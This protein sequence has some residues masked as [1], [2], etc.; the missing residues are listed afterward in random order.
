MV[1]RLELFYLFR[2]S[3][4]VYQTPAH[5]GLP[6]EQ[7]FI[8]TPDGFRLSARRLLP[9]EPVASIVYFHGNTGNLGILN[10]IFLLLC[11]HDLQLL[12]VDYRGYGWSTETPSEEGNLYGCF[13]HC[14]L[15]SRASQTA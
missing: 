8:E 9:A 11:G 12:A 7:A 6:F 4:D 14:S 3:H 13:G 1:P 2:P 5:V 10:E 15:Y